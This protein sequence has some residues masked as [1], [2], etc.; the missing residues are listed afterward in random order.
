MI[1]VFIVGIIVLSVMS[2]IGLVY[3]TKMSFS[4]DTDVCGKVTKTGKGLARLTVI[5][6]WI[7]ITWV[8]FGAIIQ[9]ALFNGV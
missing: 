8:I 5:L 9:H 6:L 1:N 3:I 4:S 7:Q 2:I